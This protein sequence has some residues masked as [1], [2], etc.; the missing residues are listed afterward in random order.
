MHLFCI[1]RW[2]MIDIQKQGVLLIEPD[3]N[4]RSYYSVP[5]NQV[6]NF[7][8]YVA[9]SANEALHTIE[10][11]K[12][13]D[14]QI[15]L[16]DTMVKDM[17]F[18]I[19]L[20]KIR[21]HATTFQASI[22]LFSNEISAEDKF[23]LKEMSVKEIFPLKVESSTLLE[24]LNKNEKDLNNNEL[25][26]KIFK[27]ESY[28]KNED[29]EKCDE[30]MKDDAFKNKLENSSNLI[31]IFGEYLLLKKE[32]VK[33]CD[34]LNNFI[35]K[36]GNKLD[37]AES[38]SVL[39]CLGKALCLS[40]K[41]KEASLIFKKLSEKSP[42]NLNHKINLSSSYI[43]SAEWEKSA[44]ILKT[45]LAIDPYNEA[46]LINSA[47]T[48]VGLNNQSEALSFLEKTAGT[49]EYHSIASFF[50][51]RG[52]SSIH[53][54]EYA[55]AVGFY[56]N[57]LFFT[58]KHTGKILFNLGL[59]LYKNNKMDEARKIFEQIKETTDAEYLAKSKNILQETK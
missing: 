52:I 23:L 7:T 48:Q 16:L 38:M 54:N 2:V 30:I 45:V 11:S 46:A 13:G 31:P 29:I 33:C 57:A 51:N 50:N 1:K 37:V 25:T 39:N 32:Y 21:N 9:A 58:K 22:Y 59:A 40:K 19:L 43:A 3:K 49:I 18:Q 41:F 44:E 34:F 27:L 8:T 28:L 5:M 36:N 24:L 26:E 55:Q 20:Q 47:Q 10:S 4:L 6:G 42:K 17:Q 35:H 56:K 12:S 14:I 15:I 53:D